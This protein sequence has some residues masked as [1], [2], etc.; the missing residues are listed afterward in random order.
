[1]KNLYNFGFVAL[2]LVVLGCNCQ[3][4]RELT[5]ESKAT[6]TATPSGAANTS[7]GSSGSSPSSSPSKTSSDDGL[8]MAKFDQLK[9]GMT[10]NEV[11]EIL[12]R[13]GVE[14]SSSR[15]GTTKIATYE[16]KGNGYEYIFC[17]FT[18]NKMTFKSQ[19][20]LK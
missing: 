5:D 6:P 15:V 4:L 18:N 10:Y 7:G 2:L 16:F 9:E 13:N 17:N 12:G 1:M 14:K 11:V 8:T 3:R 20:N 19:A